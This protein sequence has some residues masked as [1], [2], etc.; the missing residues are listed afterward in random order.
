MLAL[1]GFVGAWTVAIILAAALFVP[2]SGLSPLSAFVSFAIP[3]PII[4]WSQSMVLRRLNPNT[5]IWVLASAVGWSGFLGVEIFQSDA[6][7]AV[8]EL[9]GRLVSTFAGYAVASGVGATL[10]GGTVA[11]AVTGIALM[12]LVDTSVGRA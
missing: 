3:T 5:R 2:F 6:L 7:P 8:N 1:A 11:G 10:L 4:G 9:A 12:T